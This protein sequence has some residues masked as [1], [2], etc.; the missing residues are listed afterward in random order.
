MTGDQILLCCEAVN[1]KIIHFIENT[2]KYLIIILKLQYQ[3]N[4]RRF[5]QNTICY[6]VIF[7]F[8]CHLCFSVETVEVI[9]FNNGKYLKFLIFHQMQCRFSS[10]LFLI[11][12]E[13]LQEHSLNCCLLSNCFSK[14]YCIVSIAHFTFKTVNRFHSRYFLSPFVLRILKK[15]KIRIL[16]VLQYRIH[17]ATPVHA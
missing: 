2:S 8:L 7:Q 10:R 6:K 5:N 16:D 1:S 3:V 4:I 12:S 9:I 13:T 14:I 11:S 17:K 15:E